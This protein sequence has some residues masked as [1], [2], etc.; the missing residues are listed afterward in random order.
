M[1]CVNILAYDTRK[2]NPPPSQP[3]TKALMIQPQHHTIKNIDI[4]IHIKL[5]LIFN[6]YF[7]DSIVIFFL[8]EWIINP[9]VMSLRMCNFQILNFINIFNF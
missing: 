9:N 8:N 7:K 5:R 6:M 2:L 4:R 3:Y 1:S